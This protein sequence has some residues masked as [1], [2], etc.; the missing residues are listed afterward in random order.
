MFWFIHYPFWLFWIPRYKKTWKTHGFI[1]TF[2][3]FIGSAIFGA[4]IALNI[5]IGWFIH[6]WLHGYVCL[7]PKYLSR[8]LRLEPHED[9]YLIKCS[10]KIPCNGCLTHHGHVRALVHEQ[11]KF[12]LNDDGT[13]SPYERKDR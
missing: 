4:M 1:R 2:L 12:F 10:D 13:L 11:T 9:Y 6:L 8:N 5:G 3:H 7:V